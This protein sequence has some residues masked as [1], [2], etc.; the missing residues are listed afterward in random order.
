MTLTYSVVIKDLWGYW[1]AFQAQPTH[2]NRFCFHLARLFARQWQS[3]KKPLI[4]RFT[5][6]ENLK[7]NIVGYSQISCISNGIPFSYKSDPPVSQIGRPVSPPPNPIPVDGSCQIQANGV[8]GEFAR[9]R[10]PLRMI[11]HI[12]IIYLNNCIVV[13][14]L[15]RVFDAYWSFLR[16]TA[17]MYSTVHVKENGQ[18]T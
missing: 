7:V 8:G 12:P 4:W 2:F 18:W 10:L 17:W 14:A 3:S 5:S 15:G 13:L 1:G 16:L 11:V 6:S 9:S